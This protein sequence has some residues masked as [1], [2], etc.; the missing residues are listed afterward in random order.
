MSVHA[1]NGI[2]CFRERFEGLLL[3]TAV[4][5][6]IGLPAEGM[7]AARIRRLW[8]GRWEHRFFFGHGMLSDDSE[9]TLMVGQA[10]LQHPADDRAFARALA[11]KLRWWLAAL[12]AGVGLATL[13]SILKWFPQAVAA[14]QI[15]SLKGRRP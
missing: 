14:I 10:L 7:S 11:W 8:G 15:N 5:D 2:D 9:H 3:G 13:R 4:G 12:P 1:A 6:A